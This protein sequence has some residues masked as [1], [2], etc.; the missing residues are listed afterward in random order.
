MVSQLRYY[1]HYVLITRPADT[2]HLGHL[3]DATPILLPSTR[4]LVTNSQHLRDQLETRKLDQVHTNTLERV[5][6]WTLLAC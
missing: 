6:S 5:S 1:Q 3:L 2:Y 4:P